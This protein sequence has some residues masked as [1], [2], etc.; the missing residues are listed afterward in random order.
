MLRNIFWGRLTE[1]PCL[2][3]C[4]VWPRM[5]QLHPGDH[6]PMHSELFCRNALL[7][8]VNGRGCPDEEPSGQSDKLL[9]Y[10]R[11]R[12]VGGPG[13]SWRKKTSALMA[14]R[15]QKSSS[16][17]SDAELSSMGVSRTSVFAS[18]RATCMLGSSQRLAIN[19]QTTF[20]SFARPAKRVLR[21]WALDSIVPHSSREE[22]WW[23]QDHALRREQ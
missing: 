10:L 19:T 17:S 20:G 23:G 12:P 8:E 15:C 22:F 1:R 6:M 9:H 5:Q 13:R 4:A 3:A 14:S 11:A 21:S 18:D 7:D 16:M 2:S